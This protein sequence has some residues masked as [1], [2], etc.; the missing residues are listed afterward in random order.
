MAFHSDTVRYYASFLLRMIQRDENAGQAPASVV[1]PRLEAQVL[2]MLRRR[3]G[4]TPEQVAFQADHLHEAC[5]RVEASAYGHDIERIADAVRLYG[6]EAVVDHLME[7]REAAP[8]ATSAPQSVPSNAPAEPQDDTATDARRYVPSH[9]ER[10]LVYAVL[11][12]ALVLAVLAGLFGG[13]I[14]PRRGGGGE[15]FC[16]SLTCYTSE[17][18]EVPVL[19]RNMLVIEHKLGGRPSIVQIWVSRTKDPVAATL[20]TIDP[21]GNPRAIE[22]D[23]DKIYVAVP[24][25]ASFTLYDPVRGSP[26]QADKAYIRIVAMR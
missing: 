13:M 25:D 6:E 4:L 7:D 22:V 9:A 5:R 3:E 19:G 10:R 1:L 12:G 17:W 18:L 26:E 21:N 16:P 20:A 8:V 15:P 11:A 23:Q 14:A 2:T 24:P